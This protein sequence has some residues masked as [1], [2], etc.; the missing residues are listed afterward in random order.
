MLSRRGFLVAGASTVLVGA[1]VAA[2]VATDVLPGRGWA[3]RHLGLVGEPGVVPDDVP[4]PRHDATFTSAARG[5]DVAWTVAY[6]P[7][8]TPGDTLGVCVVLHG[9]GG[10]HTSAFDTGLHLDRYLAAAVA[11]G[12]PAFAL[13]SVDGGNGYWHPRAS[14]DDA[15]AMVLDE[16]VPRLAELGLATDRIG[17]LGWSMGGYG[18]LRLGALRGAGTAAVVAESPALWEDA[19]DTAP[20]AFDDAEDFAEHDVMGHQADL[21]GAPVRVDCGTADPFAPATRAY[22]DGFATPPA[23]GFEPG[24]HTNDYW[25]RMA[26]AQLTF[27][28]RHLAG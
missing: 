25:R 12:T 10:D 16:L 9:K 27:L 3:L 11:A 18:A 13:A 5:T 17:F 7:G 2:G 21:A 24:E 15:G 23:G 1:G 26:P 8:S 14:G 19:A 20:G 22:R 4:G 6:P 28:G